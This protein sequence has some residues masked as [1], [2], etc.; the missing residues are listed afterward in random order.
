MK[1]LLIIGIYVSFYVYIILSLQ[2]TSSRRL[3]HLE[4]LVD[5][6]KAATKELLWLSEREE[7]EVSRDW[8]ARNLNMADVQEY[9]EVELFSIG[10]SNSADGLHLV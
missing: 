8:S 4:Q 5:F 2:Q 7:A 1:I 10:W 9:Y 3:H 6:M